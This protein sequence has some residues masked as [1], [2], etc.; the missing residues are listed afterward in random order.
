MNILITGASGLIGTAL[1]GTLTSHGHTV[2]P[3]VRNEQCKTPFYWLPSKNKIHLDNSIKIDAVI[4]LAGEN[5][6]DKRWTEK[7]KAEILN[8]R[9]NT[10]KL[11]TNALA[12]LNNK[13]KVLISG[14]AIGFYGDTG[15]RTVD[16]NSSLGTGFLSEV[17]NKWENA[18][19]SAEKAGIRT[20]HIRTGIVLSTHGGILKQMKLPFTLG[21]GGVVGNG[22]QYL[23]CV[24]INEVT[25]MIEFLLDNESIT[26]PV[27]LVSRKPVTNDE[28]TRA[29]GQALHR[30]AIIPLP[31]FLARVLFGEM[32]DALLL[33]STKVLPGR[34]Q[35]AGYQFKDENLETTLKSLLDKNK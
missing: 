18:T 11:L 24:S 14:S 15:D 27:N 25:N 12:Q 19:Q 26:G 16:E 6:A 33:S 8:S 22:K 1:T 21:L 17:A 31:A 30:P 34:L 13:P 35:T 28:F 4:H 10:T 3:L 2:Y 9:V 23:S 7:R 32:A 29:L 5:I 20:V